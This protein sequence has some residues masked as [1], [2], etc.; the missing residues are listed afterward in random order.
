[1]R[2]QDL[3][4]GELIGRQCMVAGMGLKGKIIDESKNIIEIRTTEDIKKI[5]KK[6]HKF[7]IDNITIKG[8]N[9]NMDPVERT[10]KIKIEET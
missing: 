6:D 9:I 5:K 3:L 2:K 7:I 8:K 4:R 10:Q 1:M